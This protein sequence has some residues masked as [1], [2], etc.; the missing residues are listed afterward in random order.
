[1]RCLSVYKDLYVFFHSFPL[2]IKVFAILY[3]L[4]NIY[5]TVA[6]QA[7]VYFAKKFNHKLI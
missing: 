3:Y 1:M 5:Y 2:K 6:K 4:C 7:L